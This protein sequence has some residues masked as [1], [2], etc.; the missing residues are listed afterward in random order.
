MAWVHHNLINKT[1]L[2]ACLFSQQMSLDISNNYPDTAT[3]EKVNRCLEMQCSV[4]KVAYI[5]PE[6]LTFSVSNFGSSAE[7]HNHPTQVSILILLRVIVCY[8]S[9]GI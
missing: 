2:N 5:T 9:E 1:S 3:G 6:R 7:V 4:L 8:S